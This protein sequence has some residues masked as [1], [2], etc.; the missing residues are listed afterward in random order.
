MEIILL[1][2]V[3]NLGEKDDV[4][5][6]K[7]GYANNYLIP[8]G[9]AIAATKANKKVVAENLRQAEHRQ[10]KI[11]DEA[12][13]QA[14][15]LDNFVVRIPSLAGKDGKLFGSVTALQIANS[16][17]DKGFE[18]DRR[19]IIMPDNIKTLGD[20]E[21]QVSLHKEVRATIKVEVVPREDE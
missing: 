8:Q 3:I 16:L 2:P 1:S 21:V 9:F 11:K 20:Y 5:K 15:L 18:V 19:K 17:K 7:P 4:V 10:A 14:Q 12:E 13:N 6:V